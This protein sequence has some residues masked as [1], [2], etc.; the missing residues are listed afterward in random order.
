MVDALNKNGCIWQTGSW[1]R[2]VPNFHRACELVRNGRIGKVHHIEV[3]LGGTHSI[4]GDDG[5]DKTVK[6]ILA[7]AFAALLFVGPVLA[8]EQVDLDDPDQAKSGTSTYTIS[9]FNMN[10]T[11]KRVVI[12][13]LG[14]NGEQKTVVYDDA[15]DMIRALN[16]ANLSVKSLHRRVMERLLADG[17]LTGTISGT[18]D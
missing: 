14:S 15:G 10:W 1:Q 6:A 3:G 18:P 2:S 12:V 8:G 13:L 9:E 11:Q 5:K 4:F 17:H 16:K 7:I